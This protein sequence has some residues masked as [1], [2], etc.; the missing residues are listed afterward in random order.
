MFRLRRQVLWHSFFQPLRSK[1]QAFDPARRLRLRNATNIPDLDR[2]DLRQLNDE[3]VTIE[4]VAAPAALLDDS[5]T[6]ERR[7]NLP[8][9]SLKLL[10]HARANPDFV[11]RN[12]DKNMGLCVIPTATYR[13][14]GAGHLQDPNTYRLIPPDQVDQTLCAA[15]DQLQL[16][17]LNYRN[18]VLQYQQDFMLEYAKPGIA[19]YPHFHFSPKLHKTPM[20][21]RPLLGAHSAPTTGA[22][23]FLG[24]WLRH[25]LRRHIQHTVQQERKSHFVLLNSTSLLTRLDQLPLPPGCVLISF[26]I[27]S[28]YPSLPFSLIHESLSWFL[29]LPSSA[30]ACPFSM[31]QLLRALASFVIKHCYGHFDGH[32]YQQ[33]SG[34]AMGTNAAV[35]LATIAILYLECKPAVEL[36]IRKL[37]LLYGRY[38]DD[39]F[40]VLASMAELAPF[41]RVI[42]ELLPGSLRFTWHVSTV[43]ADFLDLHLFKGPRFS[44]H[45]LLD[46][47]THQKVLNTYQY[48]PLCTAHALHV[49]ISWIRAE[50]LR[51]VRNCSDLDSYL[52]LSRLFYYRLRARGYAPKFLRRIFGSVRYESRTALLSLVPITKPSGTR[53]NNQ[54]TA[55]LVLPFSYTT[56]ANSSRLHQLLEQHCP[57][58]LKHYSI[59]IA[60]K[61]PSH[62]GSH[63]MRMEFPN[64]NPNRIR[65]D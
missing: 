28:L 48:L 15:Y 40:A 7:R 27:E 32:Y 31:R 55:T 35:E 44:Q 1:P 38:I 37:T 22:S 5:K 61:V 2:P 21:A 33:V 56:Q 41:Q 9:G 46:S 16:L 4:N 65:G 10:H 36:L 50:L 59:R 52:D 47:R 63:F 30:L 14:M 18:C 58:L 60:W 24:V 13:A 20:G 51:H 26:D 45:H 3:L 34:L 54:H 57:T 23:K 12:A 29:E 8:P 53:S 49:K 19:K 25:L 62:L 64:R 17:L 39:G 6:H 11:I 43:S 42:S